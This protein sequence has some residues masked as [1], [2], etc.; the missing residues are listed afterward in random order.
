MC[1]WCIPHLF[2]LWFSPII[3]NHENGKLTMVAI[4]FPNGKLTLVDGHT[5]ATIIN[6]PYQPL[7]INHWSP[8]MANPSRRPLAAQAQ[9]LKLQRA[10]P[11]R[12]NF[13]QL[14]QGVLGQQWWHGFCHWLVVSFAI[15]WFVFTGWVVG[16]L[17]C[18]SLLATINHLVD[19]FKPWL[20]NNGN[21]FSGLISG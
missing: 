18:L 3:I 2:C 5:M 17:N 9:V 14:H 21:Q 7:V 15:H 8:T 6:H 11:A 4:I 16:W 12:Q 10:R 13:Q 19:G 20:I 1:H